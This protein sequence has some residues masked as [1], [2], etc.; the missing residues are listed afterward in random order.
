[1]T[2]KF[3]DY[4]C[5]LIPAID[6]GSADLRESIRIARILAAAGFGTVHCTPHRITGCYHNEPERVANATRT[7]QGVLDQEGI[8]LR[9]VPGTEHYLDEYLME[10]LPEALTFGSSR[11]LLVEA[12]FRSE[13]DF[14]AAMA[15]G[16]LQHGVVPLFA[17]PERCSP[18][19]PSLPKEGLVAKLWGKKK[20]PEM[21]GSLVLELRDAGC[22]FQGNLGSFA[23]YYG[24][25]VK[26]RALLFLRNG[27][28][29]CIGSDAHRSEGLATFLKSGLETVAATVGG[30]EATRLLRGIPLGTD[31][32]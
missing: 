21:E 3:T 26:E 17:H 14:V 18:F 30:E 16:L 25:E 15:A 8:P 10:Q 13:G 32:S 11:Y 24:M 9:L 28:Y 31:L 19:A 6:D 22:R 2:D 7:M 27:V 12:P 5:H 4:H 1:M 29:S 20:E 23:G